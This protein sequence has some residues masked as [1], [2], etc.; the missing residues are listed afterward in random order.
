MLSEQIEQDLVHGFSTGG[1]L[2]IQTIIV[3]SQTILCVCVCVCVCVC[4][5]WVK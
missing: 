4:D 5:T 3:S 1:L 2:W